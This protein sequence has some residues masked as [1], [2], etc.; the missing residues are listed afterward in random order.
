MTSTA[1][2]TF[3][4]AMTPGPPEVGGAVDRF[5]FAKTFRGDLDATGTGVMLSCGNPQTG[6]AGY[7]AIETVDGRLGGRDGGFALQQLG[8]MQHGSQ[9]LHYE[10]VPGSGARRARRHFR[11]LPPHG[12]RRHPPV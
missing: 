10:V 7:V 11:G 8:M 4:V 5:D 2:C 9:T 1:K 3:D 12:R 6:T